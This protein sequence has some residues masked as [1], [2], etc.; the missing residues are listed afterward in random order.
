MKRI[1]SDFSACDFAEWGEPELGT[2]LIVTISSAGPG[3]T[4]LFSPIRPG[5]S[6]TAQERL[7]L[8]INACSQRDHGA[9]RERDRPGNSAPVSMDSLAVMQAWGF[10]YKTNIVWHKIRKDGGSNGRGVGFYFVRSRVRFFS[11]DFRASEK[12]LAEFDTMVETPPDPGLD[13]W[14]AGTAWTSGLASRSHFERLPG[15]PKKSGW[16]SS[17][18]LPDG[19]VDVGKVV[20]LDKHR[21]PRKTRRQASFRVACGEY[22]RDFPLRQR[23]RDCIAAPRTQ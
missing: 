10:T 11:A 7:P 13:G 22:E 4:H 14:S 18:H 9:P 6:R 15:Q 17:D 1:K 12:Q 19:G 21:R 2:F 20:R 8:N 3:A 16:A 5:G 23:F